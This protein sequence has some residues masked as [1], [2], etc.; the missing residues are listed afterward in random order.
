MPDEGEPVGVCEVLVHAAVQ[1]VRD[2]AEEEMTKTF[3]ESSGL[4]ND[5]SIVGLT[6]IPEPRAWMPPAIITATLVVDPATIP[7]DVDRQGLTVSIPVAGSGYHYG[8][9]TIVLYYG[10]ARTVN[11][12]AAGSYSQPEGWFGVIAVPALRQE[13]VIYGTSETFTLTGT[14]VDITGIPKVV[15]AYGPF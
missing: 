2:K 7:A 1:T 8:S 9:G 15:G 13:S 4:P 11:L 3:V 10:P 12:G 14:A 5:P 6:I